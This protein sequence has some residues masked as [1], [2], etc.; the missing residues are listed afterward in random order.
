M[1][2][3]QREDM[4]KWLRGVTEGL[5]ELQKKWARSEDWIDQYNRPPLNK[6]PPLSAYQIAFVEELHD[7]SVF[8]E[9]YFTRLPAAL[10]MGLVE[11]L[12]LAQHEIQTEKEQLPE[13]NG[14]AKEETTEGVGSFFLPSYLREKHNRGA[15][16][17]NSSVLSL[18]GMAAECIE[19]LMDE[20]ANGSSTT[21]GAAKRASATVAAE[22]SK[23]GYDVKART[24]SDWLYKARKG[25]PLSTS[26]NSWIS[27]KNH[28]QRRQVREILQSLSKEFSRIP[29]EFGGKKKVQMV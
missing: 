4:R 12:K 16:Y 17:N 6:R 8:F 22:L 11:G 23:H 19:L 24:V 27:Q 28:P 14:E 1:S 5:E 3:V 10:S 7:L 21:R 29:A 2:D 13:Y 15:S 26:Y 9:R 25:G 18:K 20:D